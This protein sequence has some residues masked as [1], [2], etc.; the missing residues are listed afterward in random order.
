M[1]TTPY[2]LVSK[3]RPIKSLII[4]WLISIIGTTMPRPT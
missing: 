4:V 3:E 1:D 2:R